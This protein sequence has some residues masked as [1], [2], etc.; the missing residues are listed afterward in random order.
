ME[1]SKVSNRPALFHRVPS[2]LAVTQAIQRE[3]ERDRDRLRPLN[4]TPATWQTTRPIRSRSRRALEVTASNRIRTV[5]RPT[6]STT[7][8]N[9]RLRREDLETEGVKTSDP[10]MTEAGEEAGAAVE[11]EVSVLT[12][13][14]T[15]RS[16]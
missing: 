16:W 9:A 15:T 12:R 2:N 11:G 3:R 13:R 4:L 7:E 8:R 10:A 14:M 6:K 5:T 1:A